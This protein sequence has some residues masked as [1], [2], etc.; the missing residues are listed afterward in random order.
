MGELRYTMQVPET[1]AQSILKDFVERYVDREKLRKNILM[2]E[3][4]FCMPQKWQM[5]LPIFWSLNLWII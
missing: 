4:S 2:R 1:V 3:D 5:L